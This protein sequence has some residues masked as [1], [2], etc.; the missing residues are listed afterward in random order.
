[1]EYY[2]IS[3]FSEYY[4]REC[5]FEIDEVNEQKISQKF[6]EL[7]GSRNHFEIKSIDIDLIDHDISFFLTRALEHGKVS[8]S[9]TSVSHLL[10][11]EDRTRLIHK[12]DLGR[13]V[14]TSFRVDEENKLSSIDVVFNHGHDIL[15]KI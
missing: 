14:V 2:Q 3:F 9:K 6:D 12:Y 10:Y 13:M 5:W 8:F 7:V 4:D 15:A 1:M 11:G